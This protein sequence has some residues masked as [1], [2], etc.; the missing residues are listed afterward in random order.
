MKLLKEITIGSY[1]FFHM[2]DDYKSHDYDILCIYDDVFWDDKKT[3]RT[4]KDGKDYIIIKKMSKT[5]LINICLHDDNTLSVGKFLVPEFA[6]YIGLTINDLK[7][8]KGKIYSVDSTH[9]YQKLIY[10]YYIRNNDFT[11]NDKQRQNCYIIYKKE[12]E[13]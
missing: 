11:L 6:K 5:E 7:T 1:P 2:Y 4:Q 13:Y 10:K 9:S 12:R 8:L 3:M